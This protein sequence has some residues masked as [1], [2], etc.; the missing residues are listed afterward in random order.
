M[1]KIIIGIDPGIADT[2]FGVVEKKRD[3]RM[4]CLEYGSI[5]TSPKENFEDRLLKLYNELNEVIEKYDESQN[6]SANLQSREVFG[7]MAGN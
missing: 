1:E 2:G 5:K 7:G 3:G 6:L 4:V